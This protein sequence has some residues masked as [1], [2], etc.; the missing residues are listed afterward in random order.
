VQAYRGYLIGHNLFTGCFWV[1]KGGAY[2]CTCS[3]LASCYA[4]IDGLV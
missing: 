1:E 3:T 2:I 4:A